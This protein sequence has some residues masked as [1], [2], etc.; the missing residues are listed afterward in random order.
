MDQILNETKSRF[1]DELEKLNKIQEA[2]NNKLDK[3]KQ[4]DIFI[5]KLQYLNELVEEWNES[6]W[7]LLVES[8]VVH[9]DKTITFK[10]YGGHE[11]TI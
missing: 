11:I 5:K 4:I 7:N 10:F 6:I 1:D 8:A 2:I 3:G 9:I